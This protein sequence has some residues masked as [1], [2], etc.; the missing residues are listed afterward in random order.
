MRT[1]AL[2]CLPLALLA[3]SPKA[4]A[5]AAGLALTPVAGENW[6][7]DPAVSH[8]RFLGRHAGKPFEGEFQRFAASIRFD[9]A[10]PANAAAIV[11]VDVESAKTGDT[12]RDTNVRTDDWFDVKRHPIARFESTAVRDLGEGHY[13]LLGDLEIKGV[14]TPVMLPFTLSQDGRRATVKG[15]A[16]L[17]RFTLGLGLTSD[18]KEEWVA[19]SIRFELDLQADAKTGS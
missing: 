15:G 2:L 10:D 9:P 7:I 8:L 16:D 5:P 12:F 1:L 17:D 18:P 3:C 13:A 6:T 19:R 14:K 4:E 11:L